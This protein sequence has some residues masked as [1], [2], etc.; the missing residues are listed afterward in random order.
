[1]SI[2]N[3]CKHHCSHRP[4]I[5]GYDSF[6]KLL[7]ILL[8]VIF[9]GNASADQTEITPLSFGRFVVA[10]NATVST[11]TIYHDGKNPRATN[12]IYPIEQGRPG[13]YFLSGFPAFTPLDITVIANDD[14]TTDGPTEEF[15]VSDVTFDDVTTDANGEGTLII[16]ATLSTSGNGT[17]YVSSDYDAVIMINISF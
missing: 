6:F 17:G 13:E 14:L 3:Y 4:N 12:N 15:V 10:N 16:G 8:L 11:L 5:S 1:V 9:I 2:K 7:P